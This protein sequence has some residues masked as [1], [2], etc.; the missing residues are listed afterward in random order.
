[1]GFTT[2]DPFGV[3]FDARLSE[4]TQGHG[5][6]VFFDAAGAINALNVCVE[7]TKPTGHVVV[8]AISGTPYPLDLG[9]IFMKELNLVGV[10]IH[11]YYDFKSTAELVSGGALNEEPGTMISGVFSLDEV[12][13][14]FDY[15]TTDASAFKTLVR[16]N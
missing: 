5:F 16:V 2:P 6:D 7:N 8:I 1:M 13:Q 14:A 9:K 15:A 4:L 12:I 10:R 11:T 3:G